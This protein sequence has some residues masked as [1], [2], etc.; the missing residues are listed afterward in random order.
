M[1][2]TNTSTDGERELFYAPTPISLKRQT[3]QEQLSQRL[4]AEIEQLRLVAI[5]SF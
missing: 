3:K 1:A 2:T 5:S 4:T